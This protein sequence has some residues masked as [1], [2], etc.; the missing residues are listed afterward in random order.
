MMARAAT[1]A[2]IDLVRRAGDCV[3]VRAWRPDFHQGTAP[4][5]L[6]Q[7]VDFLVGNLGVQP[8]VQ[9]SAISV[10]RQKMAKRRALL[11]ADLQRR[12]EPVELRTQSRIQRDL[13]H[14]V[15]P[16]PL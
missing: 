13:A 6:P 1:K 8:R 3:T 12:V 9:E 16:R 7:L 11:V 2:G 15:L 4:R 14:S 10:F 5:L